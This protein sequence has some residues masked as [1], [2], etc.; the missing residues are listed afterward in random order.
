[1]TDGKE[2]QFTTVL[3]A[4]LAI[5]ALGLIGVASLL[6]EIIQEMVPVGLITAGIN[7]AYWG[8][9]YTKPTSLVHYVLS[10]AGLVAFFLAALLIPQYRGSL[11]RRTGTVPLAVL[12]GYGLVGVVAN[13]RSHYWPEFGVNQ[14]LGIVG[15]MGHIG[16]F[17]LGVLYHPD[18]PQNG[19][20]A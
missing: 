2:V 14:R 19:D 18:E 13:I 6:G 4:H 9:V 5:H 17:A 1:M 10:A 8:A 12:L 16:D 3:I 15:R 7:E 20:M 11:D